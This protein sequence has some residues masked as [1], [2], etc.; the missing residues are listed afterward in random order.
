MKNVTKKFPLRVLLTVTTGR[1]LTEQ[2]SEDDNGIGDLYDILGWMTDDSP[3]THQLGRFAEEC[4]PSLL[5]WFP[6]LEHCG[7][8]DSLARLDEL[9]LA[10]KDRT[11]TRSITAWLDELKDKYS[12]QD[13]YDVGKIVR[14]NIP[15][16]ILYTN[17]FYIK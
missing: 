4:K 9:L 11:K 15:N 10:D 5:K 7:S 6:E 16:K 1:L 8:C 2:K 14:Q 17:L 3:M 13:E 12:L